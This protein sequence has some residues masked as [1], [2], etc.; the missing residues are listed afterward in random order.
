MVCVQQWDE[1][2]TVIILLYGTGQAL[3][4][5]PNNYVKG[6]AWYEAI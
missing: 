5:K 3:Y 4:A 1:K 2:D 6:R